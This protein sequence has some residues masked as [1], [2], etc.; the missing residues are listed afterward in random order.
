MKNIT[1]AAE[2]V[3][4]IHDGATVLIGGFEPHR[5]C[6]RPFGLSYAATAG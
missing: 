4:Q 3:A 2:A 1:T 5:D 6:R